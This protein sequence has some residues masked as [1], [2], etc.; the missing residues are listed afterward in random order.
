MN[1]IH[2]KFF[3]LG[4]IQPE[5]PYFFQTTLKYPNPAEELRSVVENLMRSGHETTDLLT[6]LEWLRTQLSEDE[7]DYV[8]DV[9][10]FLTGWCSPHLHIQM[11]LKTAIATEVNINK[12]RKSMPIYQEFRP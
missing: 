2:F 10:D 6:E 1:D 8:L 5:I 3:A 9:M 7:E 11:P 4:M 12:E